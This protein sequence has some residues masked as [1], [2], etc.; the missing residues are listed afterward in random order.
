MASG[1]D[2]VRRG[3]EPQLRIAL[4]ATEAMS[5]AV[6]HAYPPG[7]PGRIEVSAD[8]EDG[9]FEIVVSDDGT[10]LRAG[11]SG[12][13]GA[14]LALIAQTADRFAIRQRTPRGIEVWMR[15]PLAPG[16]PS[17]PACAL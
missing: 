11:E 3:L 4:A 12:G 7:D 2:D 10:G 9:E 13:L 6:R 17:R 8:I 16:N 14:G 1:G 15:F 5:N